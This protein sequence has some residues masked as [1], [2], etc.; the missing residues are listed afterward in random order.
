M[1]TPMSLLRRMRDA[2]WMFWSVPYIRA[3]RN[4]FLRELRAAR[5]RNSSAHR[6]TPFAL[7]WFASF[8][9]KRICYE[10]KTSRSR[11]PV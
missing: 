3:R 11:L 9:M 10:V 6:L 4:A 2:R 8:G 1:P 5:A 7:N